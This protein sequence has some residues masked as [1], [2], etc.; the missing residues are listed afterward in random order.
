MG[1]RIGMSVSSYCEPTYAPQAPNP[2]PRNFNINEVCMIRGH[3]ILRVN[4]PDATSYEGNKILFF[5]DTDYMHI[6]Q[7]KTLDPH[8]SSNKNFYSPFAR[9]EPTDAGW[10]AARA[11]AYIL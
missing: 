6:K 1:L 7:Q 2:D 3:T 11:L 5:R 10:D 4:Y 8:F 9:F